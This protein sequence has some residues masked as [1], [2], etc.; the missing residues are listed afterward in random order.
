MDHV[1]EIDVAVGTDT[2]R[3]GAAEV[4]SIRWSRVMDTGATGHGID[5]AGVCIDTAQMAG[6]VAVENGAILVD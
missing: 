6:G 5:D 1:T 2:E 3:T 4:G